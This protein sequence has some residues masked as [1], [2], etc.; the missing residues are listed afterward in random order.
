VEEAGPEEIAGDY[1]LV[2]HGKDISAEVKE[3]VPIRL[4]ADGTITGAVSG[5]WTAGEDGRI[6]LTV[7]GEEYDGIRL[8]AW[9]PKAEAYTETFS[10]LSGKGIALWGA[11]RPAP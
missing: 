9:D 11:R 1:E 7:D 10:A 4:E 6:R 8:R 2:N 3:S 5:R